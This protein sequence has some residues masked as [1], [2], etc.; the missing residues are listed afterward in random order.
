MTDHEH[1]SH[2]PKKPKEHDD[3][4][5]CEKVIEPASSVEPGA[6]DEPPPSH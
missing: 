3:G 2:P 6:P 4:K 5:D 1:H